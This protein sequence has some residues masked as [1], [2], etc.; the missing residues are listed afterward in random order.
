MLDWESWIYCRLIDGT[1]PADHVRFAAAATGFM[2][3]LYEDPRLTAILERRRAPSRDLRRFVKETLRIKWPWVLYELQDRLDSASSGVT[4]GSASRRQE[5]PIVLAPPLLLLPVDDETNLMQRGRLEAALARLAEAERKAAADR[6]R[7]PRNQGGPQQ[8]HGRWLY[9]MEYAKPRRT[10]AEIGRG[11]EAHRLH[12]HRP[13][14]NCYKVVKRG[15]REACR[16]L[17]LCAITWETEYQK[18]PSAALRR[19]VR[20]VVRAWEV[21]WR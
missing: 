7:G 14:C 6:R 9:E 12:R 2:D 19:V 21:G 13:V 17:N 8:R 10:L 20:A 16:L 15:V 3:A 4:K 11:L 5:T 18:A 1:S